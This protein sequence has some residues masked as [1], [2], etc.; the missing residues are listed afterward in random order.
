MFTAISAVIC[1]QVSTGDQAVQTSVATWAAAR[2][3]VF[4]L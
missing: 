1:V 4:G 3:G 2:P